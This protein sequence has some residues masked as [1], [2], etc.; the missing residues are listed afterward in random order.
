VPHRH[1]MQMDVQ[2]L[3]KPLRRQR[4]SVVVDVKGVLNPHL[5]PGTIKYWR[6]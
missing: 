4:N 2:E 1:Y 5:L 6:L 3:L